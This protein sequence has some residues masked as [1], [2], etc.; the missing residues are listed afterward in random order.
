MDNSLHFLDFYI[1]RRSL[2]RGFPHDM[3]GF[4]KTVFYFWMRY[5]ILK[6]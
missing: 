2:R 5:D 3:M 6:Q 1:P 4:K